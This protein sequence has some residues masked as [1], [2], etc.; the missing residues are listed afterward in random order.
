MGYAFMVQRVRD[1]ERTNGWAK[2][3][4]FATTSSKERVVFIKEV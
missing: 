4:E 2:K 3:P 1:G